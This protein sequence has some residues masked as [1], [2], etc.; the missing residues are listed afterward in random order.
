MLK[1]YGKERNI[2]YVVV[3][4]DSPVITKACKTFFQ[5]LSHVYNQSHLGKHMP[6]QGQRDGILQVGK[7]FASALSDKSTGA[8]FNKL[9]EFP[10]PCEDVRV[11]CR[12]GVLKIRNLCSSDH[13]TK[14]ITYTKCKWTGFLKRDVLFLL[15]FCLFDHFNQYQH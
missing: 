12:K 14:L 15:L 2:S 6:Y 3:S 5:E 8:W 7:Q 13:V 11:K 1:P 4:P 10:E 9:G